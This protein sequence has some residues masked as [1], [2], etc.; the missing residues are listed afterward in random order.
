MYE[1]PNGSGYLRHAATCEFWNDV[2]ADPRF[3]PSRYRISDTRL[4]VFTC[5]HSRIGGKIVG[6]Q[7]INSAGLGRWIAGSN[8]ICLRV[9]RFTP[10][11]KNTWRKSRPKEDTAAMPATP[12]S[13]GV[14]RCP[15]YSRFGSKLIQASQPCIFWDPLQTKTPWGP[16]LSPFRNYFL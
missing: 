13:R 11:R 12:A 16:R 14:E 10:F 1:D 9:C 8:T 2:H 6:G 3:N 5:P 4:K 15:N 7:L